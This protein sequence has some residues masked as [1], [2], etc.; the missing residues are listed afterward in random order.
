MCALAG[1]PASPIRVISPRR[2]SPTR[3]EPIPAR[4]RLPPG[5]SADP[6]GLRFRPPADA[7]VLIEQTRQNV[8]RRLADRDLHASLLLGAA[9][10]A[11]A[12]FLAFTVESARTSD[13]LTIFLLIAA[14]AVASRVDF[15]IG[16]GYAVPTSSSSSRCSSC[17]PCRSCR[18]SWQPGCFSVGCLSTREDAFR[19]TAASAP[20][21]LVARCRPGPRSDRRR[22]A[23][24]NPSPP[25]NLRRR[26]PRAVRVRLRKHSGARSSW[27][28][29]VAPQPA[30]GHGLDLG[31][32]LG[33]DTSP[34]LAALGSLANPELVLFSL[35]LIGL[36]AH[37]ARDRK[38]H[39][40]KALELSAPIGDSLLAW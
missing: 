40:D 17:F 27:P 28:R 35:P 30:T 13:P 18:F 34:I 7:N 8:V 23:S 5:P 37:F 32:R 6:A 20:G 25:A 11:T 36:L 24:S 39:I 21:Q 33:S 22:R 12:L 38:S 4:W 2:S 15:E 31:G 1:E 14:Y 10:L 26:S 19:S 29:G 16:T 9:F 3:W